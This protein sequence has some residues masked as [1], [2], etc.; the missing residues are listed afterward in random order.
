MGHVLPLLLASVLLPNVGAIGAEMAIETLAE[1]VSRV[2][3]A[4]GLSLL[5]VQRQSGRRGARIA[6]SYVSR[7]ENGHN[8]NLTQK[9]VAA[10]ARG[11]DEPEELVMAVW[12]GRTPNKADSRELQLLAHFREL[13]EIW[14]DSLVNIARLFNAEHGAKTEEIKIVKKRHRAA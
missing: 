9:T 14:K 8:K 5:D 3:N 4:K 7:I 12:M 2:R 1:F 13:P 11:L 6:G 10:L